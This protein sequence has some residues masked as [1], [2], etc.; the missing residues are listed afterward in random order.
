MESIQYKKPYLLFFLFL[1]SIG[2][3]HSQDQKQ[4]SNR[5]EAEIK[6]ELATLEA[7]EKTLS[8][9]LDI[10]RSQISNLKEEL[11]NIRR[12]EVVEAKKEGD[13]EAERIAKMELDYQRNKAIQDRLRAEQQAQMADM[14]AASEATK[15][16]M[17]K[18]VIAANKK[19]ERDAAARKAA[20]LKKY[21]AAT[22][23]KIISHQYWI[24]MTKDMAIDSLGRPDHINR[25]VLPMVVN[26]Q[27]VY[28]GSGLYLY[29]DGDILTSFQEH[30]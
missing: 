9:A 5:S 13:K 2:F 12:P 30:R 25:T 27:W 6:S 8:S 16:R 19:A 23:T 20:L 21:D 26:E 1:V 22:H 10:I 7:K 18:E 4:R 14:A 3:A 15:K 29:F 11:G 24:G 28:D 17:E